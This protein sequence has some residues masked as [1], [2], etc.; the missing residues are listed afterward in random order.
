MPAAHQPV[1]SRNRAGQFQASWGLVV[2]ALSG[3][4]IVLFRAVMT[5]QIVFHVKGIAEGV[6]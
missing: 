5:G 1:L 4:R 3:L 6:R 2:L